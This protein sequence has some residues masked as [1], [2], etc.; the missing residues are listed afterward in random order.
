MYMHTVY[1]FI[2]R[3]YVY[4]K[5]GLCVHSWPFN[6]WFMYVAILYIFSVL[7]LQLEYQ[8]FN[9][10]NIVCLLPYLHWSFTLNDRQVHSVA[11]FCRVLENQT[12]ELKMLMWRPIGTHR[13]KCQVGSE[14]RDRKSSRSPQW[15]SSW[16]LKP[17][18]PSLRR[19]ESLSWSSLGRKSSLSKL[20]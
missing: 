1:K 18:K 19:A 9:Q 11:I 2:L 16:R 17:G 13:V 7:L 14:D 5:F 3:I 8:A 4:I 10:T 20:K 12:T 15:E 6:F